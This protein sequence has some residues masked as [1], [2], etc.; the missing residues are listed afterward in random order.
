MSKSGA[1]I[2]VTSITDVLCFATGLISQMPVV[3]LF[4]LYTTVALTMDF[5]YQV[6]KKDKNDK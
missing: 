4:C 6:R 2:S 5:I 1:S 3:R